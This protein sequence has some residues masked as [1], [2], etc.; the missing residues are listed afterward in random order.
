MFKILQQVILKHLGIQDIIEAVLERM[1]EVRKIVLLGDY[2]K[3]IDSGTIEILLVGDNLDMEYIENIELKIEK[4]IKRKVSFFL[5]NKFNI[6]QQ[7]IILF[8][9]KK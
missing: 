2:A 3:G 8:D 1:G 6:N 7:N 5:S 9:A 4:L